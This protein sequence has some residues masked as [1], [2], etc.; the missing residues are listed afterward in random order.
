[1]D[2]D[3]DQLFTRRTVLT[4]MGI[5]L[6]AAMVLASQGRVLWCQAGDYLPWSFDI[7]STHNS[8]HLLDPYSF[9]H[10]L[11]GVAE[12]WILF[13]LFGK[14]PVRWRFV[15]AVAIEACWE[16]AENSTFVIER[17][18]AATISLDYF[19]D[20][21]LNS[22]SDITFCATGFVVASKLRFWRSL[23]LFATTE[24][25]LV[26]TI[27]DS[28]LI[29]ILMLLYPIDAVKHWQMGL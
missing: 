20:S 9:T 19:G 22:L 1:M 24:T 27:H 23:I 13:L 3:K 26:L 21:I 17:Y 8:Q 28:L 15:I 5:A 14:V 12:F 25:I 2:I 10:M 11:H 6:L 18:R 7:W 29:N 4:A 16:I